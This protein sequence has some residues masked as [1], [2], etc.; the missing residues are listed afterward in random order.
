[1]F[2]LGQQGCCCGP[3][4]TAHLCEGAARFP[5]HDKLLSEVFPQ[6]RSALLPLKD[7]IKVVGQ[8]ATPIN[9]RTPQQAAFM[10]AK[11]ALCKATNLAHPDLSAQL[12]IN[13][14]ASQPTLV[15]CCNNDAV[16]RLDG[17][18]WISFPTFP[19]AQLR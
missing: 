5:G 19:T 7:V 12:S 10:A 11:Q 15:Q 13:L 8:G 1:V 4:V 18:P 3:D 14:D 2:G 6:H 17:S 16:A 9:W